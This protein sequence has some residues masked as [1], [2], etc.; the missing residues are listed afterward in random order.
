MQY[1]V[2]VARMYYWELNH[3]DLHSLETEANPKCHVDGYRLAAKDG[4]CRILAER[5]DVSQ[6]VRIVAAVSK[7]Q[8]D[9]L[10][11]TNSSVAWYHAPRKIPPSAGMHTAVVCAELELLAG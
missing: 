10:C 8:Q 5:V 6:C 3:Q 2:E 7:E 11:V 9:K 4:F 1:F